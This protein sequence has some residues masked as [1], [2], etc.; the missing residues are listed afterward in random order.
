MKDLKAFADLIKQPKKIVLLSHRNPDGDAIGSSLGLSYYLQL[1]GHQTQIILP[2]EYPLAFEWMKDANKALIY[3]LSPH[4]SEKAV[5]EAEMIICLDF[6][7]LERIDKI[8]LKVLES[9]A[10][11]VMIDH[12]LDPEPFADLVFSEIQCSSTSEIV[13]NIIVGISGEG[14]LQPDIIEALYT[15]IM[16][17]TG[18]FHHST[19]EEVFTICAHFKKLGLNDTRIQELVLNSQ[20]DKY[21]LLLGHCLHDRME[22]Y[23][24]QEFGLI[25]LT[26]ED[27]KK[28]DIRRGDTE[29]II[30]YLM[31]LKSV[32]VGALVMNQPT[33]VKLS[34]R[35]K[36]NF[37]VQEICKVNFNGGG[38]RNASGGSSKL[39]LEETLI[40]LKEVMKVKE[41]V[42]T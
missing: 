19:S 16:T 41:S 37:S 3:D 8:G 39:S 23:P 26:K 31:M 27:Y 32:K 15:G 42:N 17:D 20:P 1:K 24:E 9:K 12:H 25:Y 28:F 36:G 7:S 38:H 34:L 35:S 22:L 2:S 33:I 6:N 40:K 14:A 4:D 29:G 5:K 18:S 21:L 30:N 11:K 13:H 10:T